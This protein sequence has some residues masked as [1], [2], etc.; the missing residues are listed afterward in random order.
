MV[1]SILCFVYRQPHLDPQEFRDRTMHDW[2]PVLKR[3]LAPHHPTSATIHFPAR[4]VSGAGNRFA[5]GNMFK[6]K[7]QD[8]TPVV[9]LGGSKDP[10]MQW[11][12]VSVWRFKDE[13]SLMQASAQLNEG[14][15]GGDL[16][17][18][19]A[20]WC[21]SAKTK[22]VLLGESVELFS[23]ISGDVG[24]AETVRA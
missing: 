8:D 4:A 20:K 5:L 18:E 15:S 11:D 24:E 19:E 12:A 23:E 10:D 9:I 6:G 2:L 16:A 21:Q 7:V 14:M 1:H 3:V 22:I 17:E 13:L